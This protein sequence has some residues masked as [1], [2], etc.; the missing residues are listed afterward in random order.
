MTDFLKWEILSFSI[1]GDWGV[2]FTR[3]INL[4]TGL[5]SDTMAFLPAK[6]DSSATVPEPLKGSKI[7][8]FCGTSELA[9]I[10]K[11]GIWGITLAG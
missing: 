4:A 11:C 2:V 8:A 10:K 7:V 1:E 3:V 9:E 5:E 6:H